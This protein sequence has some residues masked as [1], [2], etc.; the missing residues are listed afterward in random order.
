MFA[1]N[2]VFYNRTFVNNYFITKKCNI[3]NVSPMHMCLDTLDISPRALANKQAETHVNMAISSFCN[4]LS[5]QTSLPYFF[6][7]FL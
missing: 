2:H 7:T 6:I 3:L 1:F 4:Q 5:A